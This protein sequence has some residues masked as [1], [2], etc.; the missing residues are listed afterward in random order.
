MMVKKAE[1][2]KKAEALLK[3]VFSSER[4]SGR[5]TNGK[6]YIYD[7]YMSYQEIANHI[8]ISREAVANIERTALKK[9]RKILKM[10]GYSA[11]SFF[12]KS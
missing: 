8:G 1:D 9:I 6:K 11:D 5:Y 7:P 3:A 2:V 10:R 4:K 12:D